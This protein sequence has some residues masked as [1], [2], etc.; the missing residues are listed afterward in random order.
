[1]KK[2][3]WAASFLLLGAL[4]SGG[5]A[6]KQDKHADSAH[7]A[8]AARSGM[9][10]HDRDLAQLVSLPAA[11]SNKPT[12][13]KKIFSATNGVTTYSGNKQ[14]L[15]FKNYL[16][17][18][19]WQELQAK[20]QESVFKMSPTSIGDGLF[21]LYFLDAYDGS[22]LDDGKIYSGKK[23]DKLME[24]NGNQ[25]TAKT[26]T[27]IKKQKWH[28]GY[29]HISKKKM[30]NITFYRV[31]NTGSFSDSTIVVTY[32]M[33]EAAIKKDRKQ[34]QKNIAQV[35]TVIASISK[36]RNAS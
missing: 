18:V 5:C 28:V 15:P 12:R 26:T 29:Q 21:D 19:D 1:M 7:S 23:L 13:I 25:F 35:K 31:E 24:E 32:S 8:Q 4:L 2:A 20:D 10:I 36:T 30:V 34:V 6:K 27:M 14:K 17:P 16:V 22:P 33:P 9:V 3:T 11:K